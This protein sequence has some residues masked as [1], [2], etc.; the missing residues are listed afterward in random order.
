M[1]QSIQTKIIIGF[2]IFWVLVLISLWM[3]GGFIAVH[4]ISK[5]W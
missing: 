4:F 1:K 2:I 3:I 5:F